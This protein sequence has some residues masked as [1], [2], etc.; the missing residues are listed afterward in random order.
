MPTDKI[1][2]INFWGRGAIYSVNAAHEIY[3]D[4]YPTPSGKWKLTGFSPILP[5][6]R[7]SDYVLSV[8]DYLLLPDDKRYYKN[9][10]SK[11]AITDL[12]HGTNRV[13]LGGGFNH[14]SVL[15]A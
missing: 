10:K 13:W 14:F 4:N 2:T 15:K 11:F 6:G 1:L 12:D 8:E 7:V 3:Y 9:G 5:G